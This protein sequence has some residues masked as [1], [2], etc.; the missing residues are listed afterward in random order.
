MTELG[1]RLKE[2]RLAKGLSL[3]D[4]QAITKIQKRYLIGIEEGNYSSMPGNFYVRA[5]VKQY[6]EALQLNPEEIFE[7]YKNEIPATHNDDLP[8]KLSRVKSRKSVSE[9]S[10]KIFD[11]I[12]KVLIGVFIIGAA[13][14][15]YYFFVNNVGDKANDQINEK[16]EPVKFVRS[17]NLDKADETEKE[18][19][20][21]N[22]EEK[23]NDQQKNDEQ[24]TVEEKP[25]VE[26]PKQEL[27]A[28]Q[29]SGKNSSY[30]L[31]N[32]DKF[33]LKLVTTGNTW[34][35]VKTGSGISK[36][37]GMLSNTGTQ[38]TEVDLA[39]E[40][41]AVIVVGNTVATEI[42]VN[43]QKLEYAIAPADQVVQ[44]ITIQYVPKNE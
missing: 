15:L 21:Q 26:T 28:V 5:F 19:T 40:S 24:K 23:K 10:S 1:N 14:L 13:G 7:T 11:I 18:D 41:K 8:E 32:A 38:S 12:P 43:D 42:Y 31:K 9:G 35:S 22:K 30:D 20:K 33:V 4:L 17:E 29:N 16:N 6:A 44:N 37:N 34:V 39:G 25:V 3:E 27:A 36:F 2:A